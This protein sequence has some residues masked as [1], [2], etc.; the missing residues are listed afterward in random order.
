M[1]RPIMNTPIDL[2]DREFLN[3]LE[4]EARERSQ[5]KG[6][7]HLWVSIYRRLE[8]VVCELDAYLARSEMNPPVLG[9]TT[10]STDEPVVIKNP[11]PNPVPGPDSPVATVPRF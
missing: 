1:N 4:T 7:N 11:L 2:N 6:T 9:Q 8:G 5:T 3:A 10:T